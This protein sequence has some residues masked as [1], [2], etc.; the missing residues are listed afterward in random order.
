[1]D[2]FGEDYSRKGLSLQQMKYFYRACEAVGVRN[3]NQTALGVGRVMAGKEG[4]KDIDKTLTRMELSLTR[5][6]MMDNI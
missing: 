4:Q 5:D 3:I 2:V 1:M 6:L